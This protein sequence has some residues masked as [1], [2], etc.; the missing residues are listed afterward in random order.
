MVGRLVEQQHVGAAEQQPSER[1]AHLPAAREL[2]RCGRSRSA[3]GEAEPGQHATDLGLDGVPAAPFELSPAAPRASRRDRSRSAPGGRVDG[4]S[5]ARICS[6][7]AEQVRDRRR[8]P[9]RAAS[10]RAARGILRQVADD[11]A[12]RQRTAAGVGLFEPGD[13]LQ[14]RRLARTVR[15]DQRGPLARLD[16]QRHAVEDALAAIVFASVLDA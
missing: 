12:R 4:R 16:H 9:R 8:A 2:L 14:Q 13:D 1:D 10:G 6:S 5:S 15:R 3:C 7:S 11:A